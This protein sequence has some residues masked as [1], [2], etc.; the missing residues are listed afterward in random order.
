MRRRCP[1][2]CLLLAV[3]AGCG[4]T[5]DRSR[6]GTDALRGTVAVV[7]D[8]EGRAEDA[9]FEVP[10]VEGQTVYEAM[11]AARD[12]GKI[13]F[14]TTD[15]AG[16]P[17]VTEIGGVSGEGDGDEGRNWMYWVNGEPAAVGIGSLKMHD[18]DELTWRFTTFDEA[19]NWEAE[20]SPRDTDEAPERGPNP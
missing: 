1:L 19:G 20:S 16:A 2:P 11:S 3:V 9:S 15:H 14:E 10:I 4:G 8:Y 18:G 17:F 6:I 12:E 7:I 5:D 13:D